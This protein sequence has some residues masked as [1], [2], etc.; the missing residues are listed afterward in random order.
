LAGRRPHHQAR[1]PDLLRLGDQEPDLHQHR[2]RHRQAKTV[3]LPTQDQRLTW[4]QACLTNNI[5]TL[6]YRVAAALLLLYAQPVV[7]IA[8]MKSADVIATPDGL[9][10][11]LGERDAVPVPQ[12]FAPA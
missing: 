1:H 2:H 10:L 7:K 9:R 8:A 6:P 3:P 4:L 12:P 5:D 11:S